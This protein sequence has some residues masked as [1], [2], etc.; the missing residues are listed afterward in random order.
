MRNDLK[1]VL[2]FSLTFF[3]LDVL[4]QGRIY[5]EEFI[6]KGMM[7]Y[8]IPEN[9]NGILLIFIHHV[10]NTFIHLITFLPNLKRFSPICFGVVLS[11]WYLNNWKCYLTQITNEI[12]DTKDAYFRDFWYLIGLKFC[13]YYLPIYYTIMSTVLI[14]YLVNNYYS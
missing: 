9:F 12:Y 2:Y 11:H 1:I 4:T 8:N 10:I 13:P 5:E 14:W 6:Y 7:H 3:I